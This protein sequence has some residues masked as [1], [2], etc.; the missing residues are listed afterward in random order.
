M[1][2]TLA[3]ALLLT[4][5]ACNN[6]PKTTMTNRMTGPGQSVRLHD[7]VTAHD[8]YVFRTANNLNVGQEVENNCSFPL[9]IHARYSLIINGVNVGSGKNR[10]HGHG[11]ILHIYDSDAT[12]S[13]VYG[14]KQVRAG[15]RTYPPFAFEFGIWE[16]PSGTDLRVRSQVASCEERSGCFPFE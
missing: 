12:A 5:A 11:R 3:L 7:C 14:F 1:H 15:G 13:W 4:L 2:K 10:E 9:W 6:T 16:L 8:H